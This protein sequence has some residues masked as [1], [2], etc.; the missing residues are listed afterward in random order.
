MAL[1]IGSAAVLILAVFAAGH[2]RIALGLAA[3]A[4]VVG[5][6]LYLYY[7][8]E[9]RLALSRVP[10]SEL[11]LENVSLKP[12]VGSYRIAGR[13]TNNSAKFSVKSIDIVITVRDCPGVA[14]AEQCVTVGESREI[15]NLDVPPGA[16][17]DFAESVRF[18][19][20]KV[21]LK[22]RLDW[23]YSISQIRAE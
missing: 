6:S 7:K 10:K 8:E 4:L 18:A 2:R 13:I 15:L 21:K 22:G 5:V 9:E 12:N 23:S 3:A 19:G 16:T 14:A 11:V 1:L 17:R 20:S